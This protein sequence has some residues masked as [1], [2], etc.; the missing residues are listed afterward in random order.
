MSW[1]VNP[2]YKPLEAP[3]K[4]THNQK[5]TQQSIK[6]ILKNGTPDWIRFPK[7][8]RQFAI[9]SAQADREQSIEQARAY[10]M[11][12]MDIL[13]DYKA[14]SV[15]TISTKDFVL[16]LRNNGVPCVGIF[17]GKP[18]TVGLWAYVPTTHG[19]DVRYICYMQTPAMIEWS[20][21]NLDKHGLPDGEAYRGWRTVLSELIKKG[22]LTEQRAHEIFGRPT[23]SVV[24]RRYR[25]TLAEFRSR[26]ENIAVRDG[27]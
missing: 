4:E 12:D 11:D 22:V 2:Q 26:K 17:S 10:R 15:N 23:E 5:V 20:V 1:S 14:R 24:S 6:E 27:F 3:W 8:F 25:R 19:K 9:E 7:D 18:Q 13:G 21:L 16:K